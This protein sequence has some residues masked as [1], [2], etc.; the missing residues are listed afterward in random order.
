M[1][2]STDYPNSAFAGIQTEGTQRRAED[3]KRLS[4]VRSTASLR[5]ALCYFHQLVPYTTDAFSNQCSQKGQLHFNPNNGSS[6]CF[7]DI[8]CARGSCG[9]QWILA[10]NTHFK[11]LHLFSYCQLIG[12]THLSIQPTFFM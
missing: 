7:P 6:D 2:T 3:S 5:L 8:T 4:N 12:K 10:K 1:P 11:L 9:F